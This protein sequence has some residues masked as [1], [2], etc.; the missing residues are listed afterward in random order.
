L[1][2]PDCVLFG[3]VPTAQIH[4]IHS[5]PKNPDSESALCQIKTFGFLLCA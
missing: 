3:Q 1:F 5:H 4:A 2:H